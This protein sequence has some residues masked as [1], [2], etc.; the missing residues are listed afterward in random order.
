MIS[1]KKD[2]RLPNVH[3]SAPPPVRIL[4]QK[5]CKE[6][7]TQEISIPHSDILTT[8]SET[9]PSN[10]KKKARKQKMINEA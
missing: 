1:N 9:K 5:I 10:V 3:V 4:P 6:V 2:R 8:Q 7:E